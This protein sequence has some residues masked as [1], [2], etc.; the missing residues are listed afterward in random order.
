MIVIGMFLHLLQVCLQ[1]ILSHALKVDVDRG[2]NAIAFVDCAIPTHG[3]NHLLANI[4][5]RVSLALSV[6][7]TADRDLFGARRNALF[8]GDESIVAHSI[9]CEV[10][11]L[12]RTSPVGPWG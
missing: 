12:A 8:M 7:P 11:C 6:L 4:I 2:V 1:R 5:N 9:K 3:C 10:A